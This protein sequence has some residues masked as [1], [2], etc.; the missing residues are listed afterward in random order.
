MSSWAVIAVA[1]FCGASAGY[2][3]RDG[4]SRARRRRARERM[5]LGSAHRR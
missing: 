5:R 3:F 1:F 2:L 4:I